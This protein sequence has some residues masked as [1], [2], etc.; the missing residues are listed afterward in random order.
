MS[1]MS[2]SFEVSEQIPVQMNV[3]KRSEPVPF[4]KQVDSDESPL[5]MS[6]ENWKD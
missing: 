2:N 3:Q 4:P 6:K 5:R 1:P